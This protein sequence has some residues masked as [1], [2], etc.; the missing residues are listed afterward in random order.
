MLFVSSGYGLE[1]WRKKL[2]RYVGKRPWQYTYESLIETFTVAKILNVRG[3]F[4]YL[5]NYAAIKLDTAGRVYT[6]TSFSAALK[7]KLCLSLIQ[8]HIVKNG[9]EWGETPYILNLGTRWRW[10]P[11]F[12]F[13]PLFTPTKITPDSLSR[14]VWAGL[15][16]GPDIS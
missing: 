14:G 6:S 9:E 8:H 15:G 12:T 5:T 7:A 4:Q 16:A 1:R 2:T 3:L 10:V 11:C 13:Q